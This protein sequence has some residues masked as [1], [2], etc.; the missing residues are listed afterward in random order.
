M[1]KWLCGVM[2]AILIFAVKGV[3]VVNAETV[4]FLVSASVPLATGVTITA[5]Q[6]D[7]ATNA[8]TTVAGTTLSF[9]PMTY[10]TT[11]NIYLPNHYF[12]IDVGAVGGAGAPDVTVTYVEGA[13]PNGATNGL[14]WHSRHR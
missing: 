7:S 9:D 10:D 12:A 4:S 11:N 2:I 3:N 1:K 8:F 5:S 14:G 6:V 13:N